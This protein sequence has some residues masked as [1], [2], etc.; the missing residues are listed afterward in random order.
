MYINQLLKSYFYIK[1]SKELPKEKVV[2]LL[3]KP[4]PS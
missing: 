2:V 3:L 4:L 1:L